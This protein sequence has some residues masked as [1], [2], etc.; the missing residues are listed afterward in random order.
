MTFVRS[1]LAY[2]GNKFELLEDLL[3]E[4]PDDITDFHDVFGGSGVVTL[5]MAGKAKRRYYNEYDEVIADILKVMRDETP[6]FIEEKFDKCVDYFGLSKE[7]KEEF[8]EFRD[9]CNDKPH[10]IKW[11]VI[12][13]HCFSN[14]LRFN[15][16]ICTA[17]FG[18]RGFKPSP[19]RSKKFAETHHRL[20]GVK[21]TKRDFRKYFKKRKLRKGAFVYFDPPYLASG[22]MVYKGTWSEE[23]DAELFEICKWLDKQGIRWAM[24]NVFAHGGKVNKPLKKFA[25]NYNVVRFNANYILKKGYDQTEQGTDEVL[26]KNY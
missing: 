5:N 1:I 7:N 9:H 23:L 20:Q 26:I 10:P 15:S 4:F 22:D 25:K 24:S 11:L 18:A 13:K 6:E 17:T 3:S 21:M 19:S 16:G 14:L 12:S 2:Q 8:Y